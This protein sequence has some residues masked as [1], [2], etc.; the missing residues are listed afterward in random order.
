MGYTD[1]FFSFAMLHHIAV[2][3]VAWLCNVPDLEWV[4]VGD[5]LVLACKEDRKQNVLLTYVEVMAWLNT[6][7]NLL[8]SYLYNKDVAGYHLKISEICKALLVDEIDI[9]PI[10]YN[11]LTLSDTFQGQL[12]ILGWLQTHN[13]QRSWNPYEI[14]RVLDK[15]GRYDLPI[16]LMCSMP[17]KNILN[18]DT[19]PFQMRTRWEV[20][21]APIILCASI[22]ALRQSILVN[23][24]LEYMRKSDFVPSYSDIRSFKSK[25]LKEIISAADEQA[26]DLSLAQTNKFYAYYKNLELLARTQGKVAQELLSGLLPDQDTL[27]LLPVLEKWNDAELTRLSEV[28]SLWDEIQ[29]ESVEDPQRYIAEGLVSSLLN[30]IERIGVSD[31]DS[32]NHR[33]GSSPERIFSGFSVTDFMKEFWDNCSILGV[34]R[35]AV[36]AFLERLQVRFSS[37]SQ[38]EKDMWETTPIDADIV[39]DATW[40]G[41]AIS[42]VWDLL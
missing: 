34:D 25:V 21:E 27:E 32:T 8:K 28:S 33:F 11:L 18:S 14:S 15:D 30:T 7:V 12:M 35:E 16:F 3:M 6:K 17:L 38:T 10:S 36:S 31:F 13:N 2:I 24:Q 41:P 26:E 40:E 23:L 4:I 9:S 29:K 37:Q 5:D 39:L 1:S 22:P 19:G 20:P 42:N